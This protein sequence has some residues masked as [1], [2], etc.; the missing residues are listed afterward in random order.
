VPAGAV[1][2]AG[3]FC[4]ANRNSLVGASKA[5]LSMS[6]PGSLG[7]NSM[8]KGLSAQVVDCYRRAAECRRLAKATAKASDREFY[9]QRETAW[10]KLANR[11][12]FSEALED[13]LAEFDRARREPWRLSRADLMSLK[14]PS[15]PSCHR[16]MLF[17]AVQPTY[18]QDAIFVER[19]FFHCSGCGCL[20]D[21]RP[22][23]SLH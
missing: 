7:N 21:Y 14:A 11:F 9:L 19:A 20:S 1:R 8:L 6:A 12:Q 18:V 5:A 3:T 22:S 15:C 23:E 16:E 4:V 10:L 2:R 17:N 13:R